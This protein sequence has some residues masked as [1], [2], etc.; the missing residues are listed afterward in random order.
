[1]RFPMRFSPLSRWL[2]TLIGL[3]PRRTGLALD[4][5]TLGVAMGY[6]FRARIPRQSIRSAQR[7]KGPVFDCG[8]HGWRDTWRVNGAMTDLVDLEL[9]PPVDV[10]IMG[11]TV[12][13]RRLTVSP[14]RPQ[15]LVDAL[16]VV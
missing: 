6:A 1:M 4:D 11:K 2:F 14:E 9:D 7:R 16:Q 10:T 8:V 5:T 15:D 13:V 12:S 3:G